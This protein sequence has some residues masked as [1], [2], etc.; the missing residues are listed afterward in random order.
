V[1]EQ[2]HEVIGNKIP[3]VSVDSTG[4]HPD[5][6]APTCFSPTQRSEIPTY[7]IQVTSG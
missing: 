6:A 7:A 2:Q 4:L 3:P 1:T 5:Q